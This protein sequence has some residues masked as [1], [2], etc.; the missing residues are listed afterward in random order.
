[1]PT[2]VTAVFQLRAVA[3]TTHS[4][5][6]ATP[7]PAEFGSVDQGAPPDGVLLFA[8]GIL[9]S[10]VGVHWSLGLSAAALTVGTGWFSLRGHKARAAREELRQ[11]TRLSE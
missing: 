2:A 6:P 7:A 1:M 8:N 9:G 11:V 10:A 5:H 4:I 3:G